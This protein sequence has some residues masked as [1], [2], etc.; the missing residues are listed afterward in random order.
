[1]LFVASVPGRPNPENDQDDLVKKLLPN[2]KVSSQQLCVCAHARNSVSSTT[3][4][5]S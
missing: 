1:M 5:N 4:L 2:I 3:V